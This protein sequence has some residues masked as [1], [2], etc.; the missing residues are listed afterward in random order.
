MRVDKRE[1]WSYNLA[2]DLIKENYCFMNSFLFWGKMEKRVWFYYYF[3]FVYSMAFV[4]SSFH[5]SCCTGFCFGFCADNYSFSLLR[6]W[7]TNESNKLKKCWKSDGPFVVQHFS[8]CCNTVNWVS[9]ILLCS[10]LCFWP[11]KTASFL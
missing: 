3:F 2:Y 6:K 1:Y 9:L 8:C 4:F 11:N 7:R 5:F 10:L